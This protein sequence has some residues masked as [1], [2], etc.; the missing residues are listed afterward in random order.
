MVRHVIDDDYAP[1]TH[2]SAHFTVLMERVP[3]HPGLIC[4][5]VTNRF[6]S[7]YARQTLFEFRNML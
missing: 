2:D 5:N 6:M 3:R 7:F 4:M 1:V